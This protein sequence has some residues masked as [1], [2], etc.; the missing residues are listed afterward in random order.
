MKRQVDIFSTARREDGPLGR[1]AADLRAEPPASTIAGGSADKH[2]LP[3]V[4]NLRQSKPLSGNNALHTHLV[5]QRSE[6]LEVERKSLY[7]SAIFRSTACKRARYAYFVPVMQKMQINR[8][9]PLS[10]TMSVSDFQP[11]PTNRD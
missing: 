1:A 3:A 11:R 8:L 9:L 2:P 6:I 4:I 5:A 10:L 7:E